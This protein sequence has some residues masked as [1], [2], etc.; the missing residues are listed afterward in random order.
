MSDL[1]EQAFTPDRIAKLRETLRSN[2]KNDVL[3]AGAAFAALDE[4]ERLQGEIKADDRTAEHIEAQSAALTL[5]NARIERLEE[6]LAK[7]KADADL[8]ASEWSNEIK[9][10]NDSRKIIKCQSEQLAVFHARVMAL[11]N[12][13]MRW[14]STGCPDCGGDCA[15]A[16]PPVSCCIMRDT[17]ASLKGDA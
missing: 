15:S 11:E 4:I 5:A 17:R 9:A 14:Q 16:N 12:A 10:Y 7:S 1:V 8:C 2:P 13:L 6:A 3:Y